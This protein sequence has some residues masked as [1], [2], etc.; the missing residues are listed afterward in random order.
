MLTNKKYPYI[1]YVDKSSITIQVDKTTLVS[2]GIRILF[3][4]LKEWIEQYIEK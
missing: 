3:L 2:L 1:A 4:A